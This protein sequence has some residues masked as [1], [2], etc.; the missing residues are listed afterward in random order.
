MRKSNLSSEP[1][2]VF[3]HTFV[4]LSAF[5]S[6]AIAG[7]SAD[8]T[9]FDTASINPANSP[10]APVT[11]TQPSRSGLTGTE[12]YQA[13]PPSGE[14]SSGGTY[15]PP[16]SDRAP[17]ER[18]YAPAATTAG[19]PPPAANQPSID[20]RRRYTTVAAA[21]PTP[22]ERGE[23]IEVQTGDTLYSLSRRNGVSVSE[24]MSLNG[25][26][27]PSLKPGQ[28]LYLPASAGR[29]AAAAPRAPVTETASVEPANAPSSWT[30]TYTVQP[31]DS[32]YGIARQYNVKVSDLERFNGI[33]DVR[34]V[35]PGMTLRLPAGSGGTV[36]AA[37]PPPARAV[38]PL[39]RAAAP[40]SSGSGYASSSPTS[41]QPTIINA[42]E[43]APERVASLETATA[44]D[45][46]SSGSAAGSDKLRWP[47]TG[48]IISPFGPRADGTHND[49]I[50][51]AAPMGT[52]V[53]AAEGGVVA[54]A[55]DELKGYG[56]LV[57]LRHDNGWVTAYA[58]ADELLVKRG[59]RV[60]RGDVIARAGR[61]G[62]VDQP[63]LHFE[64]RQ[65]QRPV[66]PTPFMERM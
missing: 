48:K 45:A 25:L 2:S 35:K 20:P 65:G 60:K 11:Q 28:K 34:K 16:R 22:P 47:V 26:T 43:P 1:H 7:C 18:P 64:L 6:L 36:A 66:D 63:Q 9:R 39:P 57:L 52:D 15:Y 27:T 54:Y 59:D 33:S 49:G 62:Q 14:Y 3:R 5:C 61:T 4:G 13:P 37:E 21:T 30:R 19:A 29:A 10:P 8:V 44:T 58:H 23:A 50:N 24:M 42:R 40:L 56:N 51:V 55:G 12:G 46:S 17:V 31:G 32:L 38:E 53:H 41:A